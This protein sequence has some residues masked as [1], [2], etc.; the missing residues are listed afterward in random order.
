MVNKTFQECNSKSCNLI[1]D[2]LQIQVNKYLNKWGDSYNCEDKW[3]GDKKL[4][5][6][7]ALERA[8][9]SRL[10]NGKMHGHQ[11]RVAAL[12]TRRIKSFGVA[13]IVMN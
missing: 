10:C 12:V 4:D 8:W 7:A 5:W 9:H 13:E 2:Q 11:C 6:E 1:D 3:W